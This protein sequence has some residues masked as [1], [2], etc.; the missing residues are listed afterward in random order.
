MIENGEAFCVIDPSGK[1]YRIYA[2][3][4]VDGFPDGSLIVNRIPALLRKA[5]SGEGDRQ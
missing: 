2:N 1:I 3:G 4:K 5:A